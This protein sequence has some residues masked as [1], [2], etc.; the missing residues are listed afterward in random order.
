MADSTLVWAPT[1]P[2]SGGV[3]YR[4]PLGTTLPTNAVSA[5]NALFVDHGWLGEEGITLTV[6]RDIKKHYAFGSDLVKTTQG[7]YS[8]SIKLSLLETDPDVL[9]TVFGSNSVTMGVD[10]A[11]NRT[12]RVDHGSKLKPRSAFVIDTVDGTKKRRLVIQEGLVVDLDDVTYVNS[13]LLKYTIT[14]DCYKPATGLPEAVV[15]YI[16]D[17]GHIAGS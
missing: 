5:L 16:Q 14:I 17:T 2:D 13:D 6:D 11:G 12:I 3:F 7:T 4:A 10:G 9:E 1:R 8:E 15:E